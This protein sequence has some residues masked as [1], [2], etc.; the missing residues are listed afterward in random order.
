MCFVCGR[1]DCNLVTWENR[2]EQA[3]R[4]WSSASKSVDRPI[5]LAWQTLDG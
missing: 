5:D 2:I 1:Y 3:V 4:E